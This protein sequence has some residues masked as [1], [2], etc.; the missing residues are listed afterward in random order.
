MSG[1]DGGGTWDPGLPTK[2]ANKI[3]RTEWLAPP[4]SATEWILTIQDHFGEPYPYT[5]GA[6]KQK[7]RPKAFQ[8]ECQ[9]DRQDVKQRN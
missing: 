5:P 7:D 4:Y 9:T 2:S 8:F 1:I 6:P 3:L